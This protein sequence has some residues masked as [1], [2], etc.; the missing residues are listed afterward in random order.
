VASSDSKIT[1][2]QT[3]FQTLSSVAPTLNAASDELTKAVGYL[4]AA[5]KKLNVGISVW[6]TFADLTENPGE[7][8]YDLQQ[9]GY[10]KVNGEWGLALRHVWGDNAMDHH[11][12]EGPWLFS[13][14]PRDLRLSGVDKIPEIVEQLG[15]EASSL[16]KRVQEKTKRVRELAVAIE[17]VAKLPQEKSFNERA[18]ATAKNSLKTPEERIGEAAKIA[19]KSWILSGATAKTK[20]ESK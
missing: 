13:D 8:E 20:E 17:Q 14:G 11:S 5:L 4:D 6:V 1:K 2:I 9:I 3:H 12:S 15:S 16:V 18:I 10:T 7:G 19:A